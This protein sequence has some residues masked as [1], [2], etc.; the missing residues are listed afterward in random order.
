MCEAGV[1]GGV[2]VDGWIDGTSERA[3]KAAVCYENDPLLL[4]CK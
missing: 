3:A 1:G 4:G 2:Q